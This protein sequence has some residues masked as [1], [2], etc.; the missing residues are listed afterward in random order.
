V[1][2]GLD[3]NLLKSGQKIVI[4]G[5]TNWLGQGHDM[6]MVHEVPSV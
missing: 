6:L 2:W 1:Q 5:H 4:V 3:H